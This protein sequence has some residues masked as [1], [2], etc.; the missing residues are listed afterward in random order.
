LVG[1]KSEDGKKPVPGMRYHVTNNPRSQWSYEGIEVDNIK[2]ATNLLAR[3][4]IAKIEDHE[5]LE[6]IFRSIPVIQNDP[7]WRCRT[8]I[9]SALSGI[10]N[11]GN[12]VGT[13]VLDWKRIETTAREYVAGKIADG[14]Y[15]S[16]ADITTKPTW[17]MLENRELVA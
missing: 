12:A 5:R 8:W 6:N 11:D 1:P 14:R 3:V 13:S 17:D 16:G 2:N 10:A 15:Q 9:E 7:A 4:L